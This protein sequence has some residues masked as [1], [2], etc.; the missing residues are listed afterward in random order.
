[1]TPPSPS[2]GYS[3]FRFL[4]STGK[5]PGKRRI[6]SRA[7][8]HCRRSKKRCFHLEYSSTRPSPGIGTA[9]ALP[10]ERESDGFPLNRRSSTRG[11]SAEDV[12]AIESQNTHPSA[13]TAP[14]TSLDNAETSPANIRFIGDLNPESALLSATSTKK[15]PQNGVGVWHSDSD[16]TETSGERNMFTPASLFHTISDSHERLISPVLHEQTCAVRPLKEDFEA[17]ESFYLINIHPI[18]PCVSLPQYG[19]SQANAPERIIQEQIIC[20]LACT[21]V[22]VRSNL[23]L[24]GSAH[25]LAPTEFA[26]KI[27]ESMRLSIELALISD[28]FIVVQALTAMS[29][30]IYGRESIELA[31]Q[32]FVRAVCQGLTMGLHQPGEEKRD[33][34]VSGLFCYLWSIDRLHAA[35]QG[36]PVIMHTIDM[37][38]TPLEAA[39]GQEPGFRVFVFISVL[40]DQVIALYR[41]NASLTEIP[42]EEFPSYEEVL[43]ECGA[44]GLPARILGTCATFAACL[45]SC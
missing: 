13:G 40:L 36:R 32:F 16:Q 7:C 8:E 10:N 30:M 3:R 14:Q 37:A 21:N 4:S 23:R 18:L 11:N 28:R 20:I 2:S 25:Q 43:T 6:A 42:D 29:L 38:K 9:P 15:P 26:R 19:K 45:S 41:P 39:R 27:V 22:A 31:P 5:P 35:I 44:L 17:L 33:E 12:V 24:P 1:M 34:M